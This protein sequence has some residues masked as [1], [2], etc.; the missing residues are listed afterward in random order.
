MENHK[1]EAEIKLLKLE[2]LIRAMGKVIVAFSGGVDSTFLLWVSN[3]VLGKNAVGVTGISESVAT[4]QMLEVK[5]IADAL[6]ATHEILTTYELQ[7][8]SYSKNPVNRCYFCK[9]ELFRKI[10]EFADSRNIDLILDGSN[11]DDMSIIARA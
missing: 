11:I 7:N 6:G 9:D 8:P 10:R 3:K 4:S 2:N 5:I 1:T